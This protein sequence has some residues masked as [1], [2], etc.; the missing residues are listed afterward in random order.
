MLL[1]L[2]IFLHERLQCYKRLW[3]Q[4]AEGEIYLFLKAKRKKD[5]EN[6]NSYNEFLPYK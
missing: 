1:L 2:L 4:I 6:K 3:C 5:F